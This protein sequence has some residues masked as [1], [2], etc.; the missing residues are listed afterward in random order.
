MTHPPVLLVIFDGFGLNPSRAYNGWAQ[1]RTPHLDHYFASHPHTALQASGHAVGLPDGQFGNSEVGH[2]TL[3]S[4]RVLKQDLLRISD[5]IADGSLARLAAWQ[6]LL[7]GARRL[8][9]VGLVSDGGV[10]SHIDHLL[11]LL[12]L[13]VQAGVEPVIH[14]VTDGRDTAPRCADRFAAQVE[15]ALARLGRGRIA[16]VSGR[17]YAMD[18]AGFWPRTER[19]WRAMLRGEGET[20]PSAIDAIRNAWQ[21]GEGDEFITPTVI[22][23]AAASRIAPDEPVLFFD[24][25]SDRMRQLAA[26]MGLTDFDGFDRAGEGARRVTAMTEYDAR[27][28]FP[29]LF[30]HEAPVKVLAEVLADAGLR[31]FHCAETEKYA[32]VTHFF[33]GGREAPF[34]GE[35][36]EIIPSPQVATYDLK[37]EMSAAQVADRVIAAIDSA[38]YDFI[39]VNFANGDMVGHTAVIPAILRAVETLDLQF[40]RVA[41]AALARGFRILLTADHGN[42]DE[43]VDP[44]SGQPHTQHT[45]YPVPFLL[46]DTAEKSLGTGRGLADVAPTVLDLL[47]LAQ[48]PE[49]T[50]RSILLKAALAGGNAS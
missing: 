32:H 27:F 38:Q 37:P 9:L 30:P 34:P 21:R 16:T 1:A 39:L 50:G 41:Q 23:D 14:M 48:P 10:H 8:H 18:R 12:P 13:V 3:G 36:R 44:V 7:R 5:A 2:L 28:P 6:D 33:N 47:G 25:R 40:H 35:D 20:A 49:M 22:G 4:G 24:F 43:M 26:A 46:L 29:V 17:Y 31:Q 15:A 19:A 45:A 11:D 42:C